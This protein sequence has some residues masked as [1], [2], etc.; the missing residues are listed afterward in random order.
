MQTWQQI[1][2][3]L[4]NLWLSSL[5]AAIPIIFFFLALAVF[6]MKG[7]IA[8]TITV[9]LSLLVA[10]FFY[11]MPVDMALAS[12]TYG[13]FYGLFPIAWIIITAVFLY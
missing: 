13:F 4:G 10:I 1:Y 7:H 12:A 11:G 2:N 3:P 6:R 8:G 9:V 5:I